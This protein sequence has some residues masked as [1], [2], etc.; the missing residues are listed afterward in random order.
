MQ[1]RCKS[2]PKPE[3]EVFGRRVIISYMNQCVSSSMKA[4]GS[5][6]LWNVRGGVNYLIRVIYGE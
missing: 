3:I 1:I 6:L 2:D 4:A 5:G